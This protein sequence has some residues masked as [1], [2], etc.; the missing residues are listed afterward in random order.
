MA[1][2]VERVGNFAFTRSSSSSAS[3]HGPRFW[4][5]VK[6]RRRRGPTFAVAAVF[7]D[8]F[9]ALAAFLTVRFQNTSDG[10]FEASLGIGP[11]DSF[12]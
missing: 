12:P 9:A 8:G 6:S 1:G 4:I 7:F 3:V 11:G 2:G 10:Y 5:A